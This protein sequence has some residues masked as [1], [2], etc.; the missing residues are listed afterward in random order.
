MRGRFLWL[1]VLMM[2]PEG[3]IGMGVELGPAF[4]FLVFPHS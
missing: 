1:V 2:A 3:D 4:L